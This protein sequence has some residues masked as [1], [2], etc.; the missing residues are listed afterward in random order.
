MSFLINY[1]GKV[2]SDV[3]TISSS[4]TVSSALDLQGRALVGFLLPAAFTG[5]AVTFQVSADG[6]TYTAVY[7]TSNSALSATVTQGREYALSPTDLLTAQYVKLV[8]G[9][10]EGAARTII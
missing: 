4:G 5:T 9:S 10:S 3:V 6:V 7:N 1:Q 8:S 2:F